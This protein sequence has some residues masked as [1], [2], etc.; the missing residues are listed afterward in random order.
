MNKSLLPAEFAD[1]EVHVAEWAL[2]SF[3]ARMQHR[4]S[5]SMDRIRCFYDAMQPRAEAALAHLEGF[6]LDAMPEAE[7]RLMHLLYALAQAAMA[8]EIHGQPKVG[9]ARLPIAV[10]VLREPLPV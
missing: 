8:V 2:P 5:S 3:D 6:P 10:R 9:H 7:Q 1:L 4:A